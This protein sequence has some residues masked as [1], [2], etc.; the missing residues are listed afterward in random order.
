MKATIVGVTRTAVGLV[1]RYVPTTPMLDRFT[2]EAARQVL[3]SGVSVA[4][5]LVVTL[6]VL[7]AVVDFLGNLLSPLVHVL[8]LLGLTGGQEGVVAQGLTVLAL[9]AVVVFTGVLAETSSTAGAVRGVGRYVEAVPGVGSVYSS[10]D[11]MSDVM[12]ESDTNGFKEVKLVEFPHRGV[13]S[14]AF[15]TSAVPDDAG[16]DGM[17]VL[18]VPMAPNP[19][20]GGFMV[21]VDADQVQDIDMTVQEAFQAIITSGVAMSGSKEWFD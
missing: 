5:P 10:F 15:Q 2:F 11:Q 19:V 13:Y 4:G 12:L 1:V 18:F 14:L 17:S 16:D 8:T 9:V 3:F 21:C 7:G 20:M 6:I